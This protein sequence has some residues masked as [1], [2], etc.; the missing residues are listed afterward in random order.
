[1][2]PSK[3]LKDLICYYRVSERIEVAITSSNAKSS[4][5]QGSKRQIVGHPGPESLRAPDGYKIDTWRNRFIRP[6]N[7]RATSIMMNFITNH[8]SVPD[9]REVPLGAYPSSGSA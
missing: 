8:A 2:R 4:G 5:N 7:T 1:M 3:I 9:C 6:I